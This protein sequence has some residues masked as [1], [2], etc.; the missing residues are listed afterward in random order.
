MECRAVEAAGRKGTDAVAVARVPGEVN[1][2]LGP[3]GQVAN[4]EIVNRQ[5]VAERSA[6]TLEA[7][8]AKQRINELEDD[9]SA[10]RESLR[11]II[12]DQNLGP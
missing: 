5:L 1:R 10:S 3:V 4:L 6:G 7:D 11:R 8:A 9:L 2:E 12:R